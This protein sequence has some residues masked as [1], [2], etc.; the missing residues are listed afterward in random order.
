MHLLNRVKMNRRYA[1]VPLVNGLQPEAYRDILSSALVLAHQIQKNMDILKDPA[2]VKAVEHI[3][4]CWEG[5]LF[6]GG[7]STT[8]AMRFSQKTIPDPQIIKCF[9][10]VNPYT[11]VNHVVSA[12]R[13]VKDFSSPI[14]AKGNDY[15]VKPAKNLA[16]SQIEGE[17]QYLFHVQQFSQGAII[18]PSVP[19]GEICK[20]ISTKGYVVDAFPRNWRLEKQKLSN[21]PII[22]YIDEMFWNKIYQQQDRIKAL[23]LQLDKF[24]YPL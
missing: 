18:P 8:W 22:E 7:Q 5:K 17:E 12:E 20:V 11:L 21:T 4:E 13:F 19:I 9:F 3:W 15:L 2:K 14:Q 1:L 16:L 10:K 23:S 6:R 24:Q